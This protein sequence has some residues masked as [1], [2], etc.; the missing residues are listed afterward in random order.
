MSFLTTVSTLLVSCPVDQLSLRPRR[1]PVL[2]L[3]VFLR[4]AKMLLGTMQI[5]TTNGAQLCDLHPCLS[6][7]PFPVRADPV[8][9]CLPH[10][11]QKPIDPCLLSHLHSLQQP[12][13]PLQIA[14][15][16]S[17]PSPHL[18]LRS[19]Q[20]GLHLTTGTKLPRLLP[21][22]LLPLL[23]SLPTPR[24]LRFPLKTGVHHSRRHPA[25]LGKVQSP[26]KPRRKLPNLDNK[27]L[28]SS[29]PLSP[30]SP[31]SSARLQRVPAS[32]S[33]ARV[34]SAFPRPTPP[35]PRTY[36]AS[37]PSGSSSRGGQPVSTAHWA[38]PWKY[39]SKPSSPSTTTAPYRTL[40][41]GKSTP[42]LKS[43]LPASTSSK[44]NQNLVARPPTQS[45]DTP[46]PPP[47]PPVRR[48]GEASTSRPLISRPVAGA[49][50]C[51]F[52]CR[53]SALCR[54]PTDIDP[55]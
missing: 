34:K 5:S 36:M 33:S 41:K 26:S 22:T 31:M 43:A 37:G 55:V 25:P 32:P 23:S 1:R 28:D 52:V 47:T 49:G 20:N 29:Y 19:L 40:S 16:K 13:L 2:G 11:L 9:P 8:L 51:W 14:L 48:F 15:V 17:M 10:H 38:V 6:L 7:S 45:K 4:P 30:D 50:S 21:S 27:D 12:H 39:E 24:S 18:R 54:C 42:D 35:T 46:P 53:A 3:V 44:R